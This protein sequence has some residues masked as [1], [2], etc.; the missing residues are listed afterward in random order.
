[1]LGKWSN[2]ARAVAQ[3]PG[4]RNKKPKFKGDDGLVVEAVESGLSIHVPTPHSADELLAG[5]M[6]EEIELTGDTS[7]Q[8]HVPIRAAM[9]LVKIACSVCPT[10]ELEQCRNAIDWLMG[11]RQFHVSQFPVQVAVTPGPI[12]DGASEV[13]VL[14]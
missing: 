4:K 9:A 2:L 11:R 5:G 10:V 12:S 7:S 14:R 8:P 13:V 6:P 3:V 1:Q